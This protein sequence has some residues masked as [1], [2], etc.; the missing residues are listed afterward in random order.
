MLES[1]PPST[2]SG[3]LGSGGGL[4]GT[5]GKG[6]SSDSLREREGRPGVSFHCCSHLAGQ[7]TDKEPRGSCLL[8]PLPSSAQPFSP[9]QTPVPPQLLS[10]L[11][12]VLFLPSW[13][14]WL[15]CPSQEWGHWGPVPQPLCGCLRPESQV[16]AG[17]G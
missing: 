4:R 12:P 3:W 10:N 17:R 14:N 2:A 15:R 16:P 13:P 6:R 7:E 1:Q 9:F 8:R 11:A 5:L